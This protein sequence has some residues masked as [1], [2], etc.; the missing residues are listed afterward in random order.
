MWVKLGCGDGAYMHMY[1]NLHIPDYETAKITSETIEFHTGLSGGTTSDVLSA[2]I[3]HN[4][5][6]G[7]GLWHWFA[8]AAEI[9]HGIH[10][11]F[12]GLYNP[13][14]IAVN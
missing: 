1:L 9:L 7:Q 4:K 8:E 2:K 3:I 13:N 12:V 6:I 11:S 14:F 10:G 5:Q